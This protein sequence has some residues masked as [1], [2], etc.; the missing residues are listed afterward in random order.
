MPGRL[1]G[2]GQGR[3][4]F[5]ADHLD[6]RKKHSM[7]IIVINKSEKKKKKKKKKVGFYIRIPMVQEFSL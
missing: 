1:E 7:K 6:I 4:L 5:V 3:L 2:A